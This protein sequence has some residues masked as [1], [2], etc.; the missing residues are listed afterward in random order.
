MDGFDHYGKDTDGHN[1]LI[2]SGWSVYA[3]ET[4]P[5]DTVPARTGPYSAWCNGGLTRY[6]PGVAKIGVAFAC[7]GPV[8]VN[9]VNIYNSGFFQIFNMPGNDLGFGGNGVAVYGVAGIP[10]LVPSNTWNH[11]ELNLDATTPSA[12]TFECRVN[13][14][15]VKTGTVS[16]QWQGFNPTGTQ[17]PG[18][19]AFSGQ[20]YVDDVV[21]YSL[22]GTYNNS[23]VGNVRVGTMYPDG[24]TSVAGWTAYGAN[25]GYQTINSPAPDGDNTYLYSPRTDIVPVN[26]VFDLSPSPSMYNAA[27]GVQPFLYAKETDPAN[28]WLA[29]D[30]ISNNVYANGVTTSVS[31]NYV[32]QSWSTEVDPNTSSPWTKAGLDA[33][34]LRVRRVS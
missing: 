3:L 20:C 26:S 5:R 19:V 8:N 2:Q 28:A 34:Q 21:I 24:D 10:N 27:V 13:G 25:T 22:T 18:G 16:L 12:A 6:F 15:T 30:V 7:Y 9:I 4:G 14:I 32:Y 29:V 1:N 33:L 31:N 11:I 17:T 23:F